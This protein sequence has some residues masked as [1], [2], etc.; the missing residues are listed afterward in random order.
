MRAVR[1]AAVS[2]T[3]AG[4]LTACSAPSAP[5]EP[6][7]TPVTPAGHGAFAQCLAQHGVSTPPPGPAGAPPGV[8]QDTWQRAQQACAS[9]APGPA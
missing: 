5:V 7:A 3:A 4:I 6:S 8:D 1:F 9:L 2:V